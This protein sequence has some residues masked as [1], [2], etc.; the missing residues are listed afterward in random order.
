MNF[1]KKLAVTITGTVCLLTTMMAPVSAAMF[2]FSYFGR[3]VLDPNDIVTANGKLI[4]GPYDSATNSYKIIDI[5][6]TR[7]GNSIE[8]LLSPGSFLDNDNLLLAENPALDEF[9]FAY[10]VEGVS[11]NVFHT[12]DYIEIGDQGY[13]TGY[14]LTSFSITSIPESSLMLGILSIAALVTIKKRN[15]RFSH[16]KK[17]D[18]HN[19]GVAD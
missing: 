14:P 6:G 2:N 17:L 12:Y 9:G 7:N 18:N 3:S 4:T 1:D 10:T 5:T 11:Y 16:L 8:S 13:Y 19:S 15:G